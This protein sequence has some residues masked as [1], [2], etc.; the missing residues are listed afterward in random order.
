MSFATGFE[1]EEQAPMKVAETDRD[2][3]FPN[4]DET[5]VLLRRTTSF[6]REREKFNVELPYVQF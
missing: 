1:G 4:M 2:D 3:R 5:Y 6:D